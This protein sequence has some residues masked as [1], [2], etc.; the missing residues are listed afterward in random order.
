MQDLWWQEKAEEVHQYADTHNT[1][2]FHSATKSLYGPSRT[3]SSPLLS[4]DVLK[5]T[6]KNWETELD[7]PPSMDEIKK[8][9]SQTNSDRASKKAESLLKSTKQQAQILLRPSM[10]SWQAYGMWVK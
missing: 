7:M 10:T 4:S 6:R 2:T 5:L 1:N 8:D 3:G 9:I